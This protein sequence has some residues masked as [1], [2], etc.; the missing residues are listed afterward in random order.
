MCAD[1]V[2]KL[3]SGDAIEVLKQ[4]DDNSI[5]LVLTDPPYFLDKMDNN[6][7]HK[8]VA[9]LTDHCN[10]VKSLPP[11]MKFS[12]EQGVNFYKWYFEISKELYRALKPGGFFFSFSSPRLYHRMVSAVDDAGFLI[13][14]CFMWLYTK[15]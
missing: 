6:W 5:D 14:D 9:N 12:R 2:N 10:V 4:I 11:G 7:K 15:N 8:A 1:L 3:L 13:R